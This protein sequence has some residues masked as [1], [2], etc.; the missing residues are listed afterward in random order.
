MRPRLSI[1]ALDDEALFY[2]QQRGLS[3]DAARALLVEAFIGEVFD[4][5]DAPAIAG[6][7]RN[8]AARWLEEAS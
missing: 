5:I 7:L 4:G 8:R 2:L 3:P 6:A 1:G